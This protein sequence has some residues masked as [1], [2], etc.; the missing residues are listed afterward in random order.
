MKLRRISSVAGLTG[1]LLTL[2][3]NADANT[4]ALNTINGDAATPG[5]IANALAAAN[6]YT[7]TAIGNI[8]LSQVE[9]NRV[10]L[11]TLYG[12]K[13]T[14]G[15]VAKSIDDCKVALVAEWDAEVA[16]KQAE[17]DAN[18]AAIT[19]L[20]ADAAT[21]GSIAKAV[22]DIVGGAPA[23]LDTLKEVADLIS[24]QG[25]AHTAFI[26]AMAADKTTAENALAAHI[27]AANTAHQAILDR[28]V[29]E[30]GITDAAIATAVTDYNTVAEGKFFQIANL[31]SEITLDADKT[32]ARANLGAISTTEATQLI[33]DNKFLHNLD[34]AVVAGGKVVLDSRVAT[35]HVDYVHIVHPGGEFDDVGVINGANPGEFLIQDVIAND[36]DGETYE[37]KYVVDQSL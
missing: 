34:S 15:S 28:F 30:R 12:D 32:T 5:S 4:T 36:L 3:T 14:V 16:V 26:A 21:P 23:E 29:T 2:N 25:S 11:E 20:N 18:T 19:T 22:A 35:A 33:N 1:A 6:T 9:T 10:A 37:V 7:D 24:A 17:I 8:D 31:F 13:T 27:A